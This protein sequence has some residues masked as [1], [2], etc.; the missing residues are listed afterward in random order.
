[1]AAE[2]EGLLD[3][4]AQ[5]MTRGKSLWQMKSREAVVQV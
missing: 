1:M 2:V 3:V 4:E 5:E